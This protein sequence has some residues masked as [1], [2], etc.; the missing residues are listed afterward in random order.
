MREVAA[1]LEE[2][3][4]R[5]AEGKEENV[6]HCQADQK[7]VGFGFARS[8]IPEKSEENEAFEFERM[9]HQCREH[10]AF[11]ES[12]LGITLASIRAAQ[13]ETL[14]DLSHT[15]K[16]NHKALLESNKIQKEIRTI[17]LL[18][19]SGLAGCLIWVQANF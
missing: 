12:A 13:A 15:A 17:L 6:S 2:R 3:V 18:F 14:Q 5:N 16:S 1:N 9:L 19:V 4:V 8:A 11:K 7:A 10:T